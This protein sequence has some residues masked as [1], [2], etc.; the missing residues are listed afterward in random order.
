LVAVK[1]RLSRVHISES[2]FADNLALYAVD[3]ATFESAGRKF[4][5]VGN[6]FGLTV[7]I[8]KTKGQ[9]MNAISEGDVVLWRLEVE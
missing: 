6:Q 9:A 4:V 2:Q 7:C 5:Q 1:S 8:L 3:R